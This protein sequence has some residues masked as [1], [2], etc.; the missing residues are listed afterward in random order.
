MSKRILIIG[1]GATAQSL[2]AI[3]TL[4]GFDVTLAFG[5]KESEKHFNVIC[6]KG[7]ILLRGNGL[8]GLA[9]PK[10]T[11]DVA[12]A[13]KNSDI[14]FVSVIANF[15]EEIARIISNGLRD[16]QLI[17][18]GPGNAGA[19]VFSKVFRELSVRARVII[20][21]T[22]GNFLPAR[23]TGP[24]EVIAAAALRSKK[25]AAFPS[26]DTPEAIAA[27]DG[28]LETDPLAHVFETTLNSPNVINHLVSTVL[29][30]SKIDDKGK[31]FRLFIDG[32][33]DSVLKGLEAAEAE[34]A[35][36]LSALGYWRMPSSVDHLRIVAERGKYP[37]FDAFRGL[38]GPDSIRHRYVTEDASGAVT[39]LV[40]LA[41]LARVPVPFTEGLIALVSALNSDDYY[42]KGRNLD[43]LGLGGKT[44]PQIHEILAKGRGAITDV[45]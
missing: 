22:Q 17:L 45:I 30:A 36:V 42:G 25:I 44:L 10:L 7:G 20:A 1:Y 14:I 9:L 23:I 18:I 26:S 33:T 38:D 12:D 41:R 43:N 5:S 39:L 8:R 35:N 4:R 16:G 19:L 6:D 32:L 34:W 28:I 11:S 2:A 3:Y 29:N 37:E 15:H 27:L 24:A 21:E 13:L 31:D 40:S